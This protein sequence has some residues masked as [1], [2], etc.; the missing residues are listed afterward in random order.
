MS[1]NSSGVDWPQLPG[2]LGNGP[3]PG[4]GVAGASAGGGVLTQAKKSY[5]GIASINKSVRENKMFLRS[6]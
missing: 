6:D 3:G 4:G 1:E 5:S 2:V